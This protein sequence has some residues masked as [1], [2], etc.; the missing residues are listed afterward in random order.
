MQLVALTEAAKT[1]TTLAD[2]M[3]AERPRSLQVPK[4]EML[5][6]QDGDAAL[7]GDARAMRAHFKAQLE[8]KDD[9]LR[10]PTTVRYPSYAKERARIEKQNAVE[11]EEEEDAMEVDQE[12]QA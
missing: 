4:L 8:R 5:S 10:T 1:A 3:D 12:G 7:A 6:S 2:A 11:V 9:V